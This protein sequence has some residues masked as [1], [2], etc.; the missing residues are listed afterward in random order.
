[1]WALISSILSDSFLPSREEI[2]QSRKQEETKIRN[3]KL[4][5]IRM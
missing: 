4:L 1:M 5:E 2:I 3:Q